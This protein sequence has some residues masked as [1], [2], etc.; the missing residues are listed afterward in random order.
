MIKK[1]LKMTL[2]LLFFFSFTLSFGQTAGLSLSWNNEVGCQTFSNLEFYDPKN[3]ILI[4]DIDETDCLKVCEN[5]IVKY[6]LSNLPPG[7][8]TTWNATGG[9]ASLQSSTSCTVN[10]G[11]IGDG[12]LTF[13][14]SVPGT[15]GINSMTICIKKIPLPTANFITGLEE[16]QDSPTYLY[17]CQGQTINFTNLS[18]N[19]TGSEIVS[20]HWDFGDGTTSSAQNPQHV[21]NEQEEHTVS[22]TVTNACNCSNTYKITVMPKGEGFDISCP[23]IV[24]E[25]QKA[26][27]SLPFDGM[28][29]CRDK[30]HW[31]VS[32]GTELSEA[33]GNYEVIWNNVDASGFGTITFT[34]TDCDLPCLQPTTIRI[35]VIQSVGTIKGDQNVCLGGQPIYKLPQWPTTDFVWEITSGNSLATLVQSDQRNE[36]ILNALGEGTVTLKCVYMNTLLKCGGTAEYTIKIVKPINF[37]GETIICQGGDLSFQTENG[38]EVNWNLTGLPFLV[39]TFEPSSQ[40]NYTLPSNFVGN[41][42]LSLG[43]ES[44]SA[45]PSQTKSIRVIAKPRAPR[46]IIGETIICPDAPY[47]YK[48]ENTAAQNDYVWEVTG[49]AFVGSN[50]GTQVTVIFNATGPYNVKVYNEVLFPTTCRSVASILNVEKKVIAIEIKNNDDYYVRCTNTT[51]IY[52]AYIDGTTDLHA[53]GEQYTW[54]IDPPTAGS[55][56]SGQNTNTI[57]VLW[58]N[59]AT[60]TTPTIHLVAKECT[61]T[62]PFEKTIDLVPAPVIVI[63]TDPVNTTQCSGTEIEFTVSSTNG[64][65]LSNALVTWNFNGTTFTSTTPGDLTHSFTFTNTSGANVGK[66]VT[67][68][69]NNICSQPSNTA[70]VDLTILNGPGASISLGNGTVNSF[71]DPATINTFLIATTTSTGATFQWYK[72]GVAITGATTATL[73]ISNDAVTGFGA[74]HVVI[75][76]TN[77]CSTPSNTIFVILYCPIP[78]NCTLSPTPALTNTSGANCTTLTLQGTASDIPINQLIKVVGPENF[79]VPNNTN[80]ILTRAGIYNVFYQAFYTCTDGTTIGKAELLKQI[81]VPYIAD[82]AYTATCANNNSFTVTVIDKSEIFSPVT[83][84]DINYGW[85]IMGSTGAFTP[86]IS[87][88]VVLPQGNYQFQLTVD[89]DYASNPQTQCIKTIDNVSLQSINQSNFIKNNTIT[90]DYK[91]VNFSLNFMP[92]ETETILWTFENTTISSTL[93]LTS[94]VFNAPGTYTVTATVRNSNG[95]ERTFEKEVIVPPTCFNGDVVSNFNPATVCQGESITISYLPNADACPVTDY[96]WMKG[97]E[98]FATT[99]SIDVFESGFYWVKVFSGDG[100]EYNTP[101]RITPAFI[102]LPALRI[103]APSSA[104][105]NEIVPIEALAAETVLWTINNEPPF[106]GPVLLEFGNYPAGVHTLTAT[107]TD[108]NGCSNEVSHTITVY[109]QPATPTVNISLEC[110]PFQYTLSITNYNTAYRYNWSNGQTGQYCYATDGGAFSVTAHIGGCEVTTH[111]DLPKNPTNHTWIFPSGCFSLCAENAGYIIGPRSQF[112]EWIY[113]FNGDAVTHG[114][115]MPNPFDQLNHDGE[116]TLTLQTEGCSVTTPPL[117]LDAQGCEDCKIIKQSIVKRI[118]FADLPY[119]AFNVSLNIISTDTYPQ[120]FTLTNPDLNF[121]IVP[122]TLEILPGNHMYDVMLIPINGFAGATT[123][124]MQYYNEKGELCE[125]IIDFTI[126]NCNNNGNSK[127]AVSLEKEPLAVLTDITLYPNPAKELVH[128]AFSNATADTVVS[129]YDITGRLMQTL[130]SNTPE[131]TWQVNTSTYHRGLYIV[132]V[133]TKNNMVKQYKLIIE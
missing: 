72:N 88:Q 119:C 118:E 114:E 28:K 19:N 46:E 66:T 82:F 121:I 84:V 29:I 38:E 39:A 11:S 33:G 68:V 133:S 15:S 124:T 96:I 67:A 27:Y 53:L 78:S 45:C 95:C 44:T 103:K 92:L 117:V 62:Q 70:L 56:T 86:I 109:P 18:T 2:L 52:S 131:G 64:V 47:V 125:T 6:T 90:C 110:A 126:P 48:V 73:Q 60:A 55:I 130:Q 37:S 104:C 111:F 77:G 120:W 57:N 61:I 16:G 129:I 30:F 7:S 75:T 32:G 35:P 5:T 107:V 100:C 54:S 99:A 50:T 31:S 4:S 106:T 112:N 132:T 14:T 13:S 51:D 123:I 83:N 128:I 91:A 23:S 22:L 12:T 85:R 63:T 80:R 41:L 74:Y 87:N 36:V 81:V 65:D 89:G 71:C 40:F 49:G 43:D 101:T 122:N 17:I 115:N 34:P 9:V 76:G 3:P 42:F 58:N 116:Y 108:E 113:N 25:G 59:V 105:V 79:T 1:Y 24:C 21:F 26:T 102:T 93:P 10:W 8:I 97:N 69:I 94:R 127:K 20:Y 98:E